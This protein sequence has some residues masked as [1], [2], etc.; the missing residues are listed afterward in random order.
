[1]HP[2]IRAQ[3]LIANLDYSFTRSQV[4]SNVNRYKPSTSTDASNPPS[5]SSST[6]GATS[7]SHTSPMSGSTTSSSGSSGYHGPTTAASE[8][9]ALKTQL[10]KYAEIVQVLTREVKQLRGTGL[11]SL[12]NAIERP[13]VVS[14]SHELPQN[15]LD[16]TEYPEIEQPKSRKEWKAPPSKAS[17][18]WPEDDIVGKRGNEYSIGSPKKIKR[19]TNVIDGISER[20]SRHRKSQGSNSPEEP[21]ESPDGIESENPDDQTSQLPIDRTSRREQRPVRR[22]RDRR[23]SDVKKRRSSFD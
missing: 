23:S 22:E 14:G 20:K 21:E 4:S 8:N 18:S 19:A 11:Q 12:H 15:E 16:E 2:D 10:Q 6:I 5:G 3:Q 1:M 7:I 13:T 9:E 17:S